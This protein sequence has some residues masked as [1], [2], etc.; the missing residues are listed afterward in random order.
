MA[1]SVDVAMAAR[2]DVDAHVA[3]SSAPQILASS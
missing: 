1:P 3:P 2:V